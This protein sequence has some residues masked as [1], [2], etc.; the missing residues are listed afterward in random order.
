VPLMIASL[1]WRVPV[2]RKWMK[3]AALAVVGL[4][5]SAVLLVAAIVQAVL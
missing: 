5:G 1:A 4:V 2:L 3:I